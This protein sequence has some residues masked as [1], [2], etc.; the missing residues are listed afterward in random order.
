MLKNDKNACLIPHILPWKQACLTYKFVAYAG[1]GWESQAPAP[2][3]N[4]RIYQY[5]NAMAFKFQHVY[6]STKSSCYQ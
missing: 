5:P 1:E 3:T 6:P 2:H 4:M